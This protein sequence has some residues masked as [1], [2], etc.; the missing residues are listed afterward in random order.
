MTKEYSMEFTKEDTLLDRI[1]ELEK[2]NT[3]LKADYKVLSCSVGDFEELQNKLEEE[4]RKNNVLSDNLSEAKEFLR[5]L[6]SIVKAGC[7][8]FFKDEHK[9]ILTEIKEFL[10]KSER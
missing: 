4:Q 10:Q 3:E 6:Y 5:E 7:S 9:T 1:A 8:P 2:E